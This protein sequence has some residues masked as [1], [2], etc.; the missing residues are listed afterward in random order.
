MQKQRFDWT[1]RHIAIIR[2]RY[3]TDGPKKLA[4][5]FGTTRV[6]VTMKARRLGVEPAYRNK[7]AFVWTDE[8]I[9]T[10]HRLYAT[11][12]ADTLV[13]EVGVPLHVIRSKGRV[14]G[15]RNVTC[16]QRR[17]RTRSLT[18]M[19]VNIHFF[20]EWSADMAYILGFLFTDG[21]ITKRLYDVVIGL[22]E[23]DTCV[24]DFIKAKTKSTRK[25]D[26]RIGSVDKNGHK[27]APSVFLTLASK[28][29]VQRLMDLGMKPRKTYTDD[30]FPNVPDGM[31]PHF[32]RGA[33]DGDGTAFVSSQG[34]CRVGFV[35]SPRFIA[36]IRGALVSL[37]GMTKN[38]LVACPNTKTPCTKV[39]WGGRA[40][41]SR[42][43]DYVYPSGF[44]F[45]LERKKVVLDNW[46]AE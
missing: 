44:S 38:T 5:E 20:D 12:D 4:E 37:A 41:I 7:P 25:Y 14:L 18:Q 9:A 11:A 16:L 34:Y 8:M 13:R 29:M 33:F 39:L 40:D 19:S 32:L 2:K 28:V 1:D 10:M 3:A 21:S 15:L 36:G 17:G 23:K 43:R 24:L 35:G 42:F 30:A 45:C 22:A 31:M 26:Y 27:H 46:L 6:T